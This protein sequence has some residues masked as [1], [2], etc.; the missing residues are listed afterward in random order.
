[1]GV[2]AERRATRGWIVCPLLWTTAACTAPPRVPV[3]LHGDAADALVTI[4]DQYVGT[5]GD[6]E[7]R[8][9][10]LRPGQHRVTVEQ[11][12]FFPFDALVDV[13]DEP[14]DVQVELVP[15]PD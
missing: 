14:V 7:R 4:D 8:G 6:V 3:S 2:K 9:V 13:D 12:G 11:V 10:G 1:M 15:V 5:L